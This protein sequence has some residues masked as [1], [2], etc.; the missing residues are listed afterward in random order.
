MYAVDVLGAG[1]W[2]AV[3]AFD[4]VGC[5]LGLATSAEEVAATAARHGVTLS[6]STVL[7]ILRAQPNP[8][9]PR[10]RV[11]GIDDWALAKGHRYATVVVDLERH[12]VLDILPDRTADTVAAWLRERPCIE[13]VNGDAHSIRLHEISAYGHPRDPICLRSEYC[14]GSQSPFLGGVNS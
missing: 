12:S 10:P 7:R 1:L 3:D 4:G 11:V 14:Q 13:V 5:R 8:T 2:P 9:F 6:A